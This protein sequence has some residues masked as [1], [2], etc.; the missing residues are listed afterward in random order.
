MSQS[1]S[2]IVLESTSTSSIPKLSVTPKLSKGPV[3]HA[4]VK[5]PKVEESLFEENLPEGCGNPQGVL[6]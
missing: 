2:I 6:R 4:V 5:L 1:L 3:P